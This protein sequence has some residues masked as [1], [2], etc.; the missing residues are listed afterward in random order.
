MKNNPLQDDGDAGA[1]SGEGDHSDKDG[2]VA[3]G[4]L[5]R[6]LP[7]SLGEEYF[8]ILMFITLSSCWEFLGFPRLDHRSARAGISSES[9][10]SWEPKEGIGH[11]YQPLHCVCSSTVEQDGFSD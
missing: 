1:D 7:S 10:A 11:R 4:E 5:D 6:A 9:G 3:G 8:L 2:S